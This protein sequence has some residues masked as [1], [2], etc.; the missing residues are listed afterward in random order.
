MDQHL[1]DLMK[2]LGEAINQSMADSGEI[3]NAMARIKDEGY[4]VFL[5]LE[6]TIGFNRTEG[7]ADP[8]ETKPTARFEMTSQ[9]ERFLKA[10]RIKVEDS[11]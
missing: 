2:Q 6:A 8:S 1:K 11:R 5:V 9:D 4:D 3:A 10:L 7:S